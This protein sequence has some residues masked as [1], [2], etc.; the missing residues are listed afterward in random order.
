MW[1]MATPLAMTVLVMYYQRL[2]LHKLPPREVVVS[3]FLPLGPLGMGGYTITYLGRVARAVFPRVHFFHNLPVAGDVVYVLG[4]FV[5]LVTW[6]FGLCWLVF[7][8][9]TI[10]S[11]RPFPFNMG[12]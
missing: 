11:T 5:A 9:A 12:W 3:S 6:G 2:A 4:V 8:L 10:A 7:A 1:G